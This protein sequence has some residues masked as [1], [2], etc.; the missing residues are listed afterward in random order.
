MCKLLNSE[1][2]PVFCILKNTGA[3]AGQFRSSEFENGGPVEQE[4]A[5]VIEHEWI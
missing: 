2:H 3:G 4:V 5:Q 1:G